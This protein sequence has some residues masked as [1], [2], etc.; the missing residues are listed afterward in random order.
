MEFHPQMEEVEFIQAVDA[1]FLF[2][3]DAEYEEVTRLGCSISDNAALMVGYELA[4]GASHASLEVNLRL[5]EIMERERPTPVILAAV[6]VVRSLLREEPVA[7]EDTLRLLG[8]CKEHSSAW[9]GLGIVLCAAPGLE[10]E[11]ERIMDGW[12]GAQPGGRPS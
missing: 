2:N 6:P 12:R 7:K 10:E 1:G 11:C 3:T 4:T 9:N 5:L 8:A